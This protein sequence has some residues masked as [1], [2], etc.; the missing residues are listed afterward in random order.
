MRV[1]RLSTSVIYTCSVAPVAVYFCQP[2]ATVLFASQSGRWSITVVQSERERDSVV[3]RQCRLAVDRQA[4]EDELAGAWLAA[5]ALSP[6][7]ATRRTSARVGLAH[8]SESL[9]W[10]TGPLGHCQCSSTQQDRCGPAAYLST[11]SVSHHH[12]HMSHH[13]TCCVLEY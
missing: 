8:L 4:V 3:E 6:K 1:L 11:D 7:A 12:T 2:S 5:G 10:P 13:R 9:V